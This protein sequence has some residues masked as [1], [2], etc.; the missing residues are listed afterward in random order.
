MKT[1]FA[2]FLLLQLILI[3]CS[4]TIST[5]KKEYIL[6]NS[7]ELKSDWAINS[8]EWIL[9]NDTLTGNGSLSPWGVLVSKKQLP[10]NY[11]IDFKV[12]MTN[13]SLFE[14]M[15][16]LDKGKYIRTYLYQI[17]QNIV[18]GDGVYDKKDDSYGKRGGKTLFRKPM[19]LEN[20]K[21]YSVKIKVKN[22]QLSFSVDDKTTL[23]CSLEKS[24]LNQKGK[25][26]FITNGEVKITYLKI[27]SF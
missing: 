16:N 7:K 26:G 9:K 19:K 15:L 22:N 13:A 6:N 25:L 20:N 4:S 17:D 23:E 8:K 24:N 21:W 18:I 14:I 5:V 1:K 3:S 2:V 12:N 10:E 11:E 27:K